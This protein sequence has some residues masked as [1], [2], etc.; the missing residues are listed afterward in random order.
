M[1]ISNETYSLWEKNLSDKGFI[2]EKGFGKF[3]SPFAEIIEKRGCNLLCMH[4][5]PGFVAVVREFYA[6]MA[7]MKEDS[8]LVRGKWVPIGH[9]RINEVFKRKDPKNGSKYKKLLKEPNHEKI[10]DFLIARK[11]KWSSTKKNLQESINRGSL[12]E[13]AKVWF[14]FIA[15]VIIPIKHLS[16]IREQEAIILYALLKGYKFDVG[17]IIETSIRIFHKNVKRGLIPHPETITRLCNLAG[18][19]GIW[20]EEETC[21][22]VSPPTLTRVI[23]GPKSRM[24]KEMEIVEVNEE[25]EEEEEEQVGME[26]IPKESQLPME[27]EMHNRRSPFI[28]SPLNVKETFSEPAEC[29]RSNQGN[30]EIMDILVSMKKEMEEREKR[31]EKQQKIREEF[32]EANFRRREQQWEQ[33]LKQ[34]DEEWKEEIERRERALMQ[35]LDSKANTFYNEQLKMDED[36]LTFLENREEKMEASMM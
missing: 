1:F 25:H 34:R 11:G 31:W 3:I 10:V 28:P 13:E 27:D 4:K 20:V 21:P 12:I 30:A 18:V 7:E 8:V 16:T 29:S 22:K 15:S 5:P 14:S 32:L 33:M 26:Q 17:K 9:E 2:V 6:K 24:K 35:R 19:K 23:K 36:V